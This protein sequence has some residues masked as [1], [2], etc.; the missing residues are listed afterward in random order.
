[1]L[2][3]NRGERD[4][5]YFDSSILSC[6]VVIGFIC[7]NI[8]AMWHSTLGSFE[9]TH[10]TARTRRQDTL[11]RLTI[12]G[13]HAMTCAPLNI[14]CLAGDLSAIFPVLVSLGPWD[15]IMITGRH[16]KAVTARD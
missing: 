13:H 1:M 12:V 6:I 15:A 4:G 3:S 5:C 10:I 7:I 9:C 2:L 14:A 16:G 8:T 11:D